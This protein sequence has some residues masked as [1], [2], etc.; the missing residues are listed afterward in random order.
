MSLCQAGEAISALGEWSP[1]GVA[2]PTAGGGGGDEWATGEAAGRGGV[3]AGS[4]LFEL[5]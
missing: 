4:E 2:E 3:L 5:I 1:T